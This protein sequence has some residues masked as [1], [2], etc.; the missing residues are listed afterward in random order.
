[1]IA[2]ARSANDRACDFFGRHWLENEVSGSA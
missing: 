1:M 2:S